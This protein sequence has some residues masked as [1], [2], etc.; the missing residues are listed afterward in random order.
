MPKIP[1][2]EMD[3]YLDTSSEEY[4]PSD[5]EV[6]EN[7]QLAGE[8]K[9]ALFELEAILKNPKADMYTGEENIYAVRDPSEIA[10]QLAYLKI[11][12][13]DK[14]TD[15]ELQ[16]NLEEQISK[17]EHDLYKHYIP[18]LESKVHKFGYSNSPL[19]KYFDKKRKMDPEEVTGYFA[20]ANSA[21][22][23]SK[24][25]GEEKEDFVIDMEVVKNKFEKYQKEPTLFTFENKE[26]KLAKELFGVEWGNY[27]WNKE[28]AKIYSRE[29][30]E[31]E[32][33]RYEIFEF[34]AQEL[35]QI[36]DRM[37]NEEIKENCQKRAK[38][39][40]ERVNYLKEKLTAP[41]EMLE[42]E[43]SVR[44]LCQKI[45]EGGEASE[46]EFDEL[47]KR[48]EEIEKKKLGFSILQ[49]VKSI[50]NKARRLFL[51]E[52][53]FGEEDEKG[54]DLGNTEWAWGMLGL[55]RNASEKEVRQAYHKLARK[56][57]IDINKEKGS[58]DKMK[59]LNLAYEF[60][61][62]EKGWK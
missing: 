61:Q 23:Y 27:A 25:K 62:K 24:V 14:I 12:F 21:L 10:D 6:K 38:A 52:S 19:E 7:E 51:G 40:L 39:L 26:E 34:E 55:E 48:I 11:D 3:R 13:L 43:A 20:E 57:H 16:K 30:E 1:R 42:I 33:K 36:A 35:I 50:F 46:E 2:G 41:R 15:P 29:A 58:D 49:K 9:R 53:S 18:F 54:F 60:I 31:V 5:Y 8:V 44:D 17:V 47:K 45:E 37:L 59:K 56:Y 4:T 32:K 22:D 28:A